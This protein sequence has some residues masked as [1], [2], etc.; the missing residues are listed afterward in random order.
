MKEPELY[1]DDGRVAGESHESPLLLERLHRTLARWNA[2]RLRAEH[3]TLRWRDEIEDD[4]RMRSL[5]GEWIEAERAALRSWTRDV[6]R[7]STGFQHWFEAL[8]DD[9]RHPP[10]EV[11]DPLAERA[12]LSEARW[13]VRQELAAQAGLDALVLLTRLRMPDVPGIAPAAAANE[14]RRLVRLGHVLGAEGPANLVWESLALS[15]LAVGF[16]LNRRYGWHAVGALGA[17]ALTAPVR[18]ERMRRALVRLGLG[19]AEDDRA[20]TGDET[21]VWVREVLVPRVAEDAER[22]PL[23]AEG[24]LLWLRGAVRCS[25]RYR[26]ELAVTGPDAG[27]H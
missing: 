21:R 20:G 4:L 18:M 12:T 22:A 26:G 6:P 15:N 24:A 23:L 25:R 10:A 14:T 8:V 19:G 13:W 3:P 2:R 16:A 27:V 5:E 1:D 11:L 17:V 9:G 7:G